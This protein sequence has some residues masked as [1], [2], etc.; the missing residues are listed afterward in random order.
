M[1]RAGGLKME[2]WFISK[3]SWLAREEC[4][5]KTKGRAALCKAKCRAQV[6]LRDEG[7][8]NVST[9]NIHKHKIC[10]SIDNETIAPL[11]GSLLS[12]C[13]TNGN[14]EMGLRMAQRLVKFE[15]NYSTL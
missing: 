14:V 15:A 7:Q 5:L 3:V 6:T 4:G 13:R 11:H 10:Q 1:G 8:I 9:Q 2:L 12:A